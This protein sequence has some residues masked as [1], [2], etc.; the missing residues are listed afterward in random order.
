MSARPVIVA[1]VGN[2]AV[3]LACYTTATRQAFL[4][5]ASLS[6]YEMIDVAVADCISG[7]PSEPCDWRVA[8]VQRESERKLA[9]WVQ[10][11]RPRDHYQS[12]V[13]DDFPLAIQVEV[14]DRVGAD[15]LATATAANAL[16]QPDRSA[17]VVDAGTA[18]TVDLIDPPGV[19]QG[20]VIL[21]GRDAFSAALAVST[22]LLPLIQQQ[23]AAEPVLPGKRTEAAIGAGSYWGTIGAVR[24]VLRILSESS[25]LPPDVFVT[26]GDGQRMHSHLQLQSQFVAHL[27]VMGIALAGLDA[28]Q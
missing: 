27:S 6:R 22:D 26:G 20:G 25:E 28:P 13:H 5:S 18:I 2:S 19:F 15:R 17:I 9:M 12:V 16:R 4:A 7:L 10:R 1:D 21:P 24:E 3:K 8:S 11:H 23:Q 14:P